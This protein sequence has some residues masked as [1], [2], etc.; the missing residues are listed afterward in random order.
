MRRRRPSTCRAAAA[1]APAHARRRP[2][3]RMHFD[4]RLLQRVPCAFLPLARTARLRPSRFRLTVPNPARRRGCLPHADVG[5]LCDDDELFRPRPARASSHIA[6]AAP[7]AAQLRR[8]HRDRVVRRGIGMVSWLSSTR[9][10]PAARAHAF[11]P[12]AADD[13][14]RFLL[15][16]GRPRPLPRPAPVDPL[17]R[18]GGGF[19]D[20]DSAPRARPRSRPLFRAQTCN[21]DVLYAYLTCNNC[22]PRAVRSAVPRDAFCSPAPPRSQTTSAVR[23]AAIHRRPPAPCPVSPRPPSLSVACRR[24]PEGVRFC[25]I[26]GAM[27][28]PPPRRPLTRPFPPRSLRPKRNIR[29]A[30]AH[31]VAMYAIVQ[32]CATRIPQCH[33]LHHSHLARR[34]FAER[35]ARPGQ[36]RGDGEGAHG[37]LPGALFMLSSGPPARRS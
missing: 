19:C 12:R 35:G 34:A 1:A 13:R 2:A 4:V 24:H 16:A 22:A 20:R 18:A 30:M 11:L 10:A 36:A 21:F 14:E 17:L 31:D 26:R 15:D 3:R 7:S 23:F 32:V 27:I 9:R 28:P 8:R 6:Y 37:A 25:L 29:T 33:T 5:A